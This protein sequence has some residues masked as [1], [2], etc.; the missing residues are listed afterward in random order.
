MPNPRV[1][2]DFAIGGNPIGR[3]VFELFADVVP[4]TAENFRALCTGEKGTAKSK[5]V[6]LHYKGC[7]FHRIIKNFMI[8]GGDFTNHNGTG[9][10]S[11][12][13]EKFEDENF[14]LKHTGPMLLS[15]ANAGPGTNGSQFFVTTVKTPHLDGKH[16]V[17]GKVLKGQDVIRQCE[18]TPTGENDKPVQDVVIVNCGELKEGE[19][20]GVAEPQDGDVLPG[21][22]VD[23]GLD[24]SNVA[25]VVAAAEKVRQI[26]NSLFSAGKFAEAVA[27]YEKAVRYLNAAETDD[28]N[29]ESVK[30]AKL[31]CQSNAAMCY[32]K[33]NKY[34]DALENCEKVLA[35]DPKNIKA[36]FRKGQAQTGSK[37][38]EDAIKTFR[39][40]EK[41]DPENK[42][43]KREI[44]RVKKHHE[45]LVQ[46][47]QKA[48]S[49]MFSDD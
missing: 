1:F 41:I 5:P 47:Q 39:E 10:E 16:V 35:V 20:D 7:T 23:S 42:E 46:K 48:Y 36:L 34:A 6:P 43:A 18:Y 37:D 38:F 45:A 28:S 13:G 9:G 25:E 19:D 22:P 11:I 24:M 30:N 33:L 49:R 29:E 2:F 26:G 14:Q 15:M 4:K 40:I 3:V 8:Q 44:E 32:L 27:K 31:P 21:Y 12:Y 17:F